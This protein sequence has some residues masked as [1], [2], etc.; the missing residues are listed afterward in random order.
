MQERESVSETHDRVTVEG[1]GDDDAE[2]ESQ[3][4]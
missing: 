4:E 3:S 1:D 2:T